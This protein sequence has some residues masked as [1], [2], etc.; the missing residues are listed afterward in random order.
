MKK[1][2]KKN[3]KMKNVKKIKRSYEV[4]KEVKEKSKYTA[5]NKKV[6]LEPHNVL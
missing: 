5:T 1:N 6:D 3:E 2:V 4:S